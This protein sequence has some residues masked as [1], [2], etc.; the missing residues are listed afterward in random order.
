MEL[1]IRIYLNG[2]SIDIHIMSNTVFEV[3]D[4]QL[5]IADRFL[6]K[7][8]PPVYL[9]VISVVYFIYI[10]TLLGL[11]MFQ[12]AKMYVTY[13]DNFLQ[14]LIAIFLILRFFPFRKHE[15]HKNDAMIIFASGVFLLTNLGIKSYISNFINHTA[16]SVETKIYAS[17]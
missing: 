3:L 13:L 11:S 6:N 8:A 15:L 17:G 4:A 10:T 7:I 12:N 14:A 1:N 9:G 2:F 5:T 16:H